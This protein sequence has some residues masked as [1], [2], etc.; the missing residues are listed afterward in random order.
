MADRPILM[1][2]PMVRAILDGRK[3]QTR[4]ALSRGWSVLGSSW[5][6]R[7]HDDIWSA[8]RLD[9]ATSAGHKLRVPW[10][11]PDDEP[12]PTDEC[13]IY[14]LYPPWNIG[15]RAWVRETWAPTVNVESQSDW[16]GRPHI[17]NDDQS[18][19]IYR[20]DGEWE[21]RDGDG[22]MGGPESCWRP[23]IHMPRAYSRLTLLIEDV[24]VQRLQ[25]ISEEDAV[26]EGWP[27]AP[28]AALR[29]AYPIGWFGNLWDDIHGPGA[30]DA[31]P[32]I[33][34]LTFRPVLAN[35]DSLGAP[36]A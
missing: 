12:T 21:W 31:D 34:A 8:L 17:V 23:S 24:R 9:E 35:I 15:D 25:D 36:D 27:N 26:A 5:K 30:W 10:C 33:Y 22:F 20:A 32:W 18:V 7:K 11:H 2:A 4:R 28:G 29:D 19:T 14:A 1:S 3:T 6:S 13:A 16:P